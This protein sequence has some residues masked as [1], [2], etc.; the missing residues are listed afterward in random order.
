MQSTIGQ[1][2]RCFVSSILTKSF[3]YS[4]LVSCRDLIYPPAADMFTYILWATSLKDGKPEKIG[5]LGIGKGE[6]KIKE[7]FSNLFVTKERD[8]K[9][10]SPS[11]FIV[12]QGGVQ[13]LNFLET[14]GQTTLETQGEPAEVQNQAPTP[15]VTPKA[16]GVV[17]GIRRAILI[18]LAALF[19]LIIVIIAIISTV[20][21][22]R[23]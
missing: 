23:E 5:E 8:G 1:P 10:R 16:G 14:P 21:R 20:R 22:F 2:S 7:A 3:D 11:E 6:F 17:S 13:P 19:T 9:A 15:T 18:F 12:M 4:L